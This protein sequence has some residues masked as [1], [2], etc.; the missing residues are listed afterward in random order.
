M[1]IVWLRSESLQSLWRSIVTPNLWSIVA[2]I[3]CCCGLAVAIHIDSRLVMRLVPVAL[4][5]G[6]DRDY[7]EYRMVNFAPGDEDYRIYLLGGSQIGS[8]V[9]GVRDFGVVRDGKLL[10]HVLDGHF[11]GQTLLESLAA[12]TEL[13]ID[14][15]TYVFL[16]LSPDRLA[17]AMRGIRDDGFAFLRYNAAQRLLQ[18]RGIDI[19]D[20]DKTRRLVD[21]T[22]VMLR[23]AY[24]PLYPLAKDPV[25]RV[26]EFVRDSIASPQVIRRDPISDEQADRARIILEA[27]RD[28]VEGRGG[29]VYLLE[30]PFNMDFPKGTPG[31]DPLQHQDLMV[32][33]WLE[34]MQLKGTELTQVSELTPQ[35]YQISR[36]LGVPVVSLQDT[37]AF[38]PSLF[39]DSVHLNPEGAK[40][41]LSLFL[42]RFKTIVE[43]AGKEM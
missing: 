32:R 36:N 3:V 10:L 40:R 28:Y 23:Y 31:W 21:R 19:P 35:Y 25:V 38:P 16:H 29:H 41:A 6:H 20:P 33:K 12:V 30:L 9:H 27:T 7:S 8:T 43:R 39:Y 24:R 42:T 11:M 1:R 2:A 14:E 18:K 22:A 17:T 37:E 15:K 13:P 4:L 26:D 34:E 5:E